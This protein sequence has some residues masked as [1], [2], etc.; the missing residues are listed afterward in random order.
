MS[1][2][3]CMYVCMY[4]WAIQDNGARSLRFDIVQRNL[5]VTVLSSHL[6]QHTS[7]AP[8]STKALLATSIEQPPLCIGQ[9]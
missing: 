5:M 2:Y 8:N 9:L 3:V 6:K 1:M 7:M 4:I